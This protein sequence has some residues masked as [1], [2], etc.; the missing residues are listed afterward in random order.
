MRRCVWSNRSVRPFWLWNRSWHSSAPNWNA[1]GSHLDGVDDDPAQSMPGRSSQVRGGSVR[2]PAITESI[3]PPE[4]YAQV[5]LR[6]LARLD[7]HNRIFQGDA[8]LRLAAD[9][10]LP[11]LRL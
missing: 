4:M 6:V 3:L 1:C 7:L 11:R 2:K 8:F 10:V 5:R 9:G